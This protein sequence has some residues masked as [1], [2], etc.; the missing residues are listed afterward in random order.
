ML[1]GGRILHHLKDLLP[2]P[3]ATLLFIGYQGEGTLGPAPGRRGQGGADRRE[4]W[5][6]RCRVRSISGLS[7]HAD[8]AE[9]DAW[10]GHFATAAR[11]DGRPRAVYVTHGEPTAASAF[12][13]R[14]SRDL[15][16]AAAVPALGETVT[17]HP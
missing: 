5:P 10:I 13:A 1:T 14:I 17:L 2:D 6:V 16:A 8:R 15:G 7:A 9:L 4:D 12:A 11:D 3:R